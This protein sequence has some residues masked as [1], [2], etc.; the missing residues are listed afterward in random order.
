ML[1]REGRSYE[2][3]GSWRDIN[4]NHYNGQ[5]RT[6]S[7]SY[8]RYMNEDPRSTEQFLQAFEKPTQIYRYLGTHHRSPPIF[9][10]R[11]L[12]YMK[13]RRGRQDRMASPL[14]ID[15]IADRLLNELQERSVNELPEFTVNITSYT[16]PLAF[17]CK[18]F[19]VWLNKM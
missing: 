13:C 19:V 7:D 4:T 3:D 9:M 17:P 15:T 2:M 12:S 10:H 14:S 6:Q 8:S 11:N 18:F 16:D 5:M 1:P